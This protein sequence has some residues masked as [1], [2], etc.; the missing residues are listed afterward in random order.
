[1]LARN[2]RFRQHA[3]CQSIIVLLNLAVVAMLMIPSF[4]SSS[5]SK[6]FGKAREGLLRTLEGARGARNTD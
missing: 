2:G 6:D 3:W 4:S 1:V 5:T